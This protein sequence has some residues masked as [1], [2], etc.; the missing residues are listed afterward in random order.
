M[1]AH[2]FIAATVVVPVLAACQPAPSTPTTTH[3]TTTSTPTMPS[4]STPS[5]EELFREASDVYRGIRI[6]I[7][8][9]EAAGGAKE[10]PPSLK[11]LVT[12]ELEKNLHAV[13]VESWPQRRKIRTGPAPTVRWIRNYEGNRMAGTLIAT[14][15]CVDATKSVFTV[16]RGSPGPG[17]IQTQTF[18]YALVDGKLKAFNSDFEVVDRC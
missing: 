6:E 1:K 15:G 5:Q 16:G 4:P 18:Y 3:H 12:G 8:N 10:L 11:Q 14:L 7:D 2:R 17:V 13:Y 9:L